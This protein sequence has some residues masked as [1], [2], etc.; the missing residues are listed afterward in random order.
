M[1]HH[2]DEFYGEPVSYEEEITSW[3]DHN[4]TS[5]EVWRLQFEKA[6]RLL[7]HIDSIRS[8]FGSKIAIR[9]AFK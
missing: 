3:F 8:E 5:P 4:S 6:Q 2:I 9:K 1:T 7:N